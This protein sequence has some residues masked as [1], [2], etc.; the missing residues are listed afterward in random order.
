MKKLLLTF[1]LLSIGLVS[2]AQLITPFTAR[3]SVTQKGGIVMIANTASGC[4]TGTTACGA[5]TCAQAHA[6]VPPLGTS[7]DNDFVNTYVD[8]DGD[9][10]T[11]MSSSD[12][13]SLPS[14]SQI[15]FAG[16]YWGAG[17]TTT[18]PN[19]SHWSTRNTVQIKLNNGTYQTL[20]ADASF[21]NTA[22]YKS[23]HNFKDITSMVSAAR[24]SWK[25]YYC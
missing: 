10:S 15:T 9:P 16:L 25:I 19:G 14:C 2:S 22:G 1:T 12:S 24:C 8:I 6:E 11:F 13:L 3:Y 5:K 18:D 17:G 20:T 23:Y 4:G 7:V 21:D